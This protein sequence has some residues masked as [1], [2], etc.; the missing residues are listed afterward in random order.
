MQPL[1]PSRLAVRNKQTLTFSELHAEAV[2]AF[3][4]SGQSQSDVAR[5]LDK[6]R[7]TVHRAL[8]DDTGTFA[9][10]Q[11]DIIAL[12]TDYTV[13]DAPVFTVRRKASA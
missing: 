10:V 11:R 5:A 2:R 8:A 1:A 4:A 9:A 13:D 12:L 3:E 7:S 6:H